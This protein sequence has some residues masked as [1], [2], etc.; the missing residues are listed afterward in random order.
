LNHKNDEII[1]PSFNNVSDFQAIKAVGAKPVLC[2][3]HDKTL[4]IDFDKAEKLITKKT[5]AVIVMDYNCFLANHDQAKNFAIKHN[6][7]IIHDAAHSF[8][9]FYKNKPIGSFGDITMFSFDPIK[10]VT[11]IDGGALIL[12]NKKMLRKAR[13]MRL[14]GTVQNTKILYKNSRSWTYDV[15]NIGFRYHLANSHASIGLQNIKKLGII[16]STRVDAC[17]LYNKLLSGLKYLRVPETD[18]KNVIPFLYHIRVKK[19]Y[20]RK[21]MAYLEKNNISTGIHWVPGH[22][23]SLL[24]KCRKGN[25][26][27]TEKLNDEIISLPLYSKINLKDVKIVCNSIRSFFKKCSGL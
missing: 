18:F 21:L 26:D 8:G 6:I 27:I 14:I 4:T 25:L 3:V 13:E 24:K 22:K 9:S 1:T 16:K 20:R 17:K 5:K 19:R 10:N 7:K 15:K 12:P 23:F 11:C 2:D